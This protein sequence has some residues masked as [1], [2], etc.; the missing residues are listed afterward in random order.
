MTKPYVRSLNNNQYTLLL[1]VYSLRFSTRSILSQYLGI[2]NNTS[3]YSRL[4][5]LQKH[6]FIA[7]HY[8]KDYKLAGREAE[9]YMLPKGL[10]ELRDADRLEVSDAMVAAVYKDKSVNPDFI[11]QQTLLA[12]I[13]SKLVNTYSDV[14]AFTTRD[15][16]ALDYFPKPRPDLFLSMK[17]DNTV[18]RFFVEY[19]PTSVASS[20]LRKRLEYLTRY[21]DEDHWGD[22]STPFPALLFIAETGLAEVGIRRLISRHQYHSDTDISYFTTTQKA[23]LNMTADDDAVWTSLDDPD[24]LLPL[25]DM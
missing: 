19:V 2:A 9:F 18:S 1:A 13:R 15:I 8:H 5:I 16:Q 22:T 14:Q 12:Q 3:L 4:R 25:S 10:R 17:N 21:Y 23:I 7:S 6:G 24:E 20:N 11:R